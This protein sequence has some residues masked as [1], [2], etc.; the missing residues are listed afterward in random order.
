M[1]ALLV[2]LSFF[3]SALLVTVLSVRYL[4]EQR[5]RGLEE[6]RRVQEVKQLEQIWSMS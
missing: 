6:R 3:P 5:S 4:L 1:I 2:A